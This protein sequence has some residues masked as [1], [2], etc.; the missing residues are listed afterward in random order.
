M[1]HILQNAIKF[2][3][4]G[5]QITITLSYHHID[6]VPKTASA[7]DSTEKDILDKSKSLGFLITEVVDTGLGIS[8][9]N[10]KNLFS[11]F[12]KGR[13]TILKT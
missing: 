8:S 12:N 5:G 2:T 4:I 6:F 3:Q 11:M 7:K 1:F 9:S 10:L 13:V